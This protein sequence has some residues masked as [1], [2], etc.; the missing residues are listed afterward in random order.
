MFEEHKF[1][2][3]PS[4]WDDYS[5]KTSF[6]V[7]YSGPKNIKIDLGNVKIGFKNQKHG[8]T[9]DSLDDVFDKLDS[10]WFSLGQDVEYYRSLYENFS[11]DVRNE[12]L[13]RMND[14]TA[15]HDIYS[16]ASEEDVFEN[17]L[18]RSVSTSVIQ[19]QYR[20]VLNG[21]PA[22][23]EF[24]FTYR[25][26]G[27]TQ[28]AAID[29]SFQVDPDSKPPTNVH[30]IIGRNGIGKT[31][32]LNNMVNSALSIEH[33]IGING[34]FH[35]KDKYSYTEINLPEEYFSC[36]V[37]VSFSAFDPFVPPPDQPDRSRGLAYFYIGMKKAGDFSDGHRRVTK[38][39]DDFTLD[40]LNSM[41]AC[42]SQKI[43]KERWFSAIQ[44]LESDSNFQEIGLGNLKNLDDSDALKQASLLVKNM[45][46]GHS[47][48][49]LTLTKLVETVE[50][51]TLVLMD[52]PE[53][54]LH[55]PLLSAFTRA[56]SDLLHDRNAVAIVATHSPVVVQEVPSSCVWK[57]T[58]SGNCARRDRPEIETFGENV[59]VLTREIFGLEVSK[60]GFHAMLQSAVDD[61]G[62]FEGIMNI[63]QDQLGYEAQAI[64]RAMI[65]GRDN[66]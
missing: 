47:I 46:S 66:N 35:S 52:E 24:K 29:L 12:Y 55:P 41:E 28:R 50:E 2:L 1:V 39:K 57:I 9:K 37:S 25:E 44:R 51:K 8:W 19:G 6:H 54:H 22:L 20:R 61:G 16:S 45:S 42:F 56:L 15:N 58:R 4:A 38:S 21:Q 65:R 36:V 3:N 11:D 27:G 60:S 14:V 5:F 34:K 64:L 59:G 31:T 49:L 13:K 7:I 53:S 43:K 63:Y 10:D 17:S 30:V 23:S 18:M 33:D 32:L 26:T 40:I 48:V 62:V